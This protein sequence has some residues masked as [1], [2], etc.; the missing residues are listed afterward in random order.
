MRLLS[1]DTST[2]ILSAAL[3]EYADGGD[4]RVYC[5]ERSV[6]AGLGHAR[7]AMPL[8]AGLLEEAEWELKRL[9]AIVVGAGPGS[10]TGLRI[11]Y[12]TVKGL[13]AG[14]TVP[15]LAVSSLEAFAAPHRCH[16]GIVLTAVDARK[17]RYYSTM[18][19]YGRRISPD[20]D[21]SAGELAA[22]AR[23][24]AREH[25]FEAPI[26]LTAPGAGQLYAELGGPSD[27]CLAGDW[28]RPPAAALAQLALGCVRR[29]EFDS[30]ESGPI[31]V[32]KSEA[33]I[34]IIAKKKRR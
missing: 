26:L 15:N 27:F 9:N 5:V 18:L 34:G 24:T 21:L 17:S 10:F 2:E 33:E 32:R 8:V 12:A 19:H 1:L 6:D 22:T 14:S 7:R 20:L 16:P 29:G 11:A 28:R 23:A 31:Y 25:R 4:R 13:S 30:P 3:V